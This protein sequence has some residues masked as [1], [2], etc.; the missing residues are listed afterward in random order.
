MGRLRASAE[1]ARPVA[2]AGGRAYAAAMLILASLSACAG[3]ATPGDTA[4]TGL[5]PF[6]PAEGCPAAEAGRQ[7]VT[8]GDA[9]PYFVQH[10]DGAVG[11]APV[12]LFLPGADGGQRSAGATWDAFFDDD[13][14]GCRIVMPYDTS[15]DYPDVAPPVEAV[16]DEVA[17]CFGPAP[18]VHL[19]GHSNGGYLAY[20]VVGPDFAAR[21]VSVTGAPGYFTRLKSE[22][23]EGLAFHN[24]V[25]EDDDEAW[26]AGMENAHE[27]LLAA[28]F[29]SELTIWPDTA[30]TPG[31]SW[32]GREGMFAFWDAH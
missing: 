2:G 4:G 26:V 7:E 24:A 9:G 13:P 21:F 8:E 32:D 3:G 20:N 30:H 25:G 1:H 16:L 27:A 15:G 10:P 22:K 17:A 18:A 29:S 6:V 12:V 11:E 31:R 28:G 19:A 14:R 23:L 5:E